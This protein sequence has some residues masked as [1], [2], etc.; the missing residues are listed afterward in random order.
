MA[1]AN[2]KQGKKQ[3]PNHHKPS[4]NRG[5]HKKWGG[6]QNNGRNGSYAFTNNNTN[7]NGPV[8]SNFKQPEPYVESPDIAKLMHERM[9]FLLVHLTGSVVHVT[10]RDGTK[11]EGVFHGASSEGDLGVSLK[12]AR[13]IYDPAA[14]PSENGKSNPVKKTLLIVAKDLVEIS[15]PDVDLTVGEGPVQDRDSFKTD[16]DI[17]SKMEFKERE[18]HRWN[19]EVQGSALES[20]EDMDASANNAGSWDQFAANEKLFGLKTDFDEEIYTTRL[21][22]SAP[23]YKDREKKAIEMANEIQKSTTT[24]VHLM[25]ERG[26]EVEDNGMDEEDRYGAVVREVNPN[27]YM[28]PALRKL[29]QQ[30]Q[31]QQ[32]QPAVK[33]EPLQEKPVSNLPPN[34]PLHKLTTGTPSKAVAPTGAPLSS[35]HPNMRQE[36]SAALSKIGGSVKKLGDSPSSNKHIEAEIATTFRQFALVEKDKLHAKKQALQKKEKDGRLAD[37]RNFHKTF[38]LNVPVPPDLVPLL[39]KGKKKTGSPESDKTVSLPSPEVLNKEAITKETI[40]DVAISTEEKYSEKFE[41]ESASTASPPMVAPVT[42]PPTAAATPVAVTVAAAA[43]NP[44]ES[45]KSTVVSAAPKASLVGSGFKFN[46]KASEF[47]PNPVAP[48]FVPGGSRVASNESSPFFAGRLLKKGGSTEHLS[49]TEMF[50]APFSHGK[51]VSPSS[52]GPIWPFGNKPYRHQFTQFIH[53]DEDVY[54]GYPP[55]NYPYGYPQ[56]RYPQQYM[57]G[58]AP[59][60]V[61]QPPG[62]PYMS[63]QFVPSGPI[64]GAPMQHGGSPMQHGGAPPNVTYS[65]QMPSGSPHGS[66]FPQGYPSPQRSPMIPQGIPP[67]QVY[68]YQGNPPHGAP[69]MMRYPPDMMP[70]NGSGP[71]VMMQRPMMVESNMMHCPPQEH[72]SPEIQTD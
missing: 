6:N 54:T 65:P 66:P 3:D 56:Y 50:S 5:S 29:Q 2:T 17:S 43:A 57:P 59:I 60:A 38:K 21:D 62:A 26:M 35:S 10:V 41:K 20:L 16:T 69:M 45:T 68:Q 22:R 8:E 36:S 48:A 70:P 58:M 24:N 37:L 49:V 23:G 15:A 61:Q 13:K 64:N 19:P 25:E 18:L 33:K 39:S 51:N 42:P 71:S 52:V 27:K 32:Q 31:Q 47:K 72:T 63:S 34:S 12:M 46:V 53:Y 9:L 11:F 4:Q 44:E 30:Q 40:K 1:F 67:H 28:P 14:P 7:S 55:P